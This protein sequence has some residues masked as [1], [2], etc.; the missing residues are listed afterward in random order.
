MVIVDLVP[1]ATR[2]VSRTSLA[3]CWMDHVQNSHIMQKSQAI[4]IAELA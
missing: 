1:E 2:V 4:Q 3:L